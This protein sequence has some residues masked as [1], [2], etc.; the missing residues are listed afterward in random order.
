[1]KNIKKAVIATM[2]FPLVAHAQT[3]PAVPAIDKTASVSPA[4]EL[5]S[6]PIRLDAK[7]KH[8]LALAE[9]WKNNQDNPTP[10]A[11]GSV[12]YLFGATIPTLVCAPLQVCIIRLQPGEIVNPEALHAGDTAR[13]L[14]IPAVVGSSGEGE[15]TTIVVKPTE[16]GL[17]TNLYIPTNRREYNIILKSA[18]KQW[19]PAISFNY[20]DDA[21]RAWESY[22]KEQTRAVHASTLAT[23]ENVAAL[24]FSFRL[25]GDNPKWKPQRVYTD[26]VKT[27]IQFGSVQFND[28]APALVELGKKDGVFSGPKTQLVNY[29]LIGDRYVVDKVLNRA[30][31]I[32]GVGGEQEKVTIDYFG[33][34]K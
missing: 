32:S 17:E 9:K 8:G 28:G 19:M 2:L 4:V 26:G 25:G 18:R 27:Y 20:P 10:A 6:K 30:A 34:E 33:D 13:W 23:G 7:E 12:K 11:D 16:P 29:R 21:K 22:R 3:M 24:N 15:T 31:L 1:M 14:I 5:A